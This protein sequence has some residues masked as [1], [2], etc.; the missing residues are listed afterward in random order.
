MNDKFNNW[1]EVI[2]DFFENKKEA[3]V[4]PVLK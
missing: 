1:Q 3:E 2:V 4:E